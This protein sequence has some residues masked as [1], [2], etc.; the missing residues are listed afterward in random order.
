MFVMK[1]TPKISVIIPTLN[2]YQTLLACISSI[3]KQS[4]RA[5]EIIIVDN[6]STDKTKE[7]ILKLNKK[8]KVIKYFRNIKNLGVTGGRN[9]GIEE[10][11]KSSDFLC[12]LDHDMV[13]D[14]KMLEELYK[15]SLKRKKIAVVTP[16][17]YYWDK[18]DILWS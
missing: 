9:R 18:K 6:A 7:E 14:R 16:K 11:S 8:H 1:K 5:K 3:L 15:T 13:A 2:S 17:I 10:S 12:F 4:Y